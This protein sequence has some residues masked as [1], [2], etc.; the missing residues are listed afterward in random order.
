M[1]CGKNGTFDKV[2]DL[3]QWAIITVQNST[4]NFSQE[5]EFTNSDNQLNKKVLGAFIAGWFSFSNVKP[6][7]FC[8]NL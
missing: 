3:Q 7:L 6:V 5:K 1:G 8:W 4:I 2:P